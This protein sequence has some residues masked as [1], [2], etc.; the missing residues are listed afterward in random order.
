MFVNTDNGLLI[1]K[2]NAA[3]NTNRLFSFYNDA[4]GYAQLYMYK[5]DS[6]AQVVIKA[7]G[8]SYFNGGNVGIG[9][10]NPTDGKL[11]VYGN[12]SSDWGIYAFNQ[13][14]NGIGLHVET[15]S[16]GTEQLL[17]LS[18]LTGSG[19]SNV[20]RMSVLANGNVGIGMIPIAALSSELQVIQSGQTVIAGGDTGGRAATFSGV[21]GAANSSIVTIASTNTSIGA[22]QGGEIGFAGKFTTGSNQFA[23][24]AKIMSYKADTTS[25]N[26]GGGLQFWTRANGVSTAERMRIKSNGIIYMGFIDATA[27][28]G[29]KLEV[30]GALYA[31][32]NIRTNGIFLNDSAPDDNVFEAK[33][34]GRKMALKTFF[35]SGSTESN[36][37][38]RTSTGN[39]NGATVDALVLKHLSATFTGDVIAY[40]DKKLKKNIKTLDGSKVYKMRGVSFDRKDTDKSSSGVI[41]QEIQEIAPELINETDGTL[42]VAYGNLSGYLIEAIKELKQEIEE[43]KNKPCNCNC[44]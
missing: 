5:G 15:N 6:T 30:N 43:L 27:I 44:K 32:G 37:T 40:S 9:V 1:S 36:W 4:N 38:F 31:A 3:N 18:S 21:G 20:V 24:F 7:S 34:S 8:S 33:Q 12:S 19:G 28:G 29:H 26:Y 13:S 14:A 41:A 11:Q 2:A 10:S 22:Q 16:F 35:S 23:Q 42:G 25:G 39:T 17:R